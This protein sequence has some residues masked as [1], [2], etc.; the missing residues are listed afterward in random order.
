MRQKCLVLSA[1]AMLLE[2]VPTINVASRK[3]SDLAR[4]LSLIN[5]VSKNA[6]ENL[7]DTPSSSNLAAHCLQQ[8]P[9]A[10][11]RTSVLVMS[12]SLIIS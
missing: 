4:V 5:Y 11:M 10:G 2:N 12:M 3:V 9:S 8:L 6:R 7:Y 1:A